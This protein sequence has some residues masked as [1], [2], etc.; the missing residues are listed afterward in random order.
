MPELLFQRLAGA[1]RAMVLAF[2]TLAATG[3]AA[4]ADEAAA[5]AALKAGAIVLFRHA[6]APGGGDPSGF[7]LGDCAT[8]RNL[9]ETGRA[10]ARRI[11]ERFRAEGIAV[12]KV[13]SS[14]WCRTRETAELAFAMPV[15][16]SSAFNSLFGRRER[17]AE[18]SKAALGI[19]SAWRGP[20]T[21][22]VV[23]HQLTIGPL[24]GIST[25]DGEG[26]VVRLEDGAVE[27]IGRIRP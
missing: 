18:Q 1:S 5:W 25:A 16:R 26:V 14:E 22:V 2:A 17:E 19:L 12:T 27:V 3:P 11:G 8:Q 20:G 13:I 9:S 7:R 24:T 15:E 21:L 6:T 23:S 10:Q 4:R